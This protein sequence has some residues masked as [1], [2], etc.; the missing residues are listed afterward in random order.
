MDNI[1]GR[2]GEKRLL[3]E[4]MDSHEP[5]FLAIYG[6]RRVGK[7]FLIRQFFRNAN[8]CFEITG[9]QSGSL[10]NQLA[11]FKDVFSKQFPKRKKD[12]PPENWN[13]ALRRLIA[14]VDKK[15]INGKTVFFFDELPWLAHRKSNF[16]QALDSFWNSWAS[17]K[18]NVIVIVCGS[19]ASWMLNNI[20]HNKGGLHNR[21][22]RRIRLLPF[23]LKETQ[24]YLNSRGIHLDQKQ[25]L[26][27]YLAM[28]GVPHYLK[29]IMRGQ[30]ST[31]NIN[32]IC[33]TKEGLLTDEFGKLYQSLFENSDIY[34]QVVRALSKKRM[35]LA[36]EDLLKIIK[37]K[38]GGGI[39]KVLNALEESGFIARAIPF[40]QKAKNASYR[41][42]DEYSI[43]YLT[44]I[45]HAPK[46][47]L[48]K[49][50]HDY[51]LQ[52]RSTP[53]WRSWSG[54]AFESVC[55]K[56]TDQIKAGLGIG[57]MSTMESSWHYR[58]RS[59]KETGAQI[60]L[61]IDR[62]D[63]CITICEMKFSDLEFVID[64][65]YHKELRCKIDCF[66]NATRSKKTLFLA[67]LTT[68]GVKKNQYSEEIVSEDLKMNVLFQ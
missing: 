59:Q 58:P 25:I 15:N 38:T 12:L 39:T 18:K 26:E 28:G 68:Y 10:K 36:R 13:E 30:S 23:T 67:L 55:Q 40:G 33:F 17:R 57:G 1:I 16:L 51:W 45:E 22:T 6:R 34:M 62:S 8:F 44:W 48:N 14:E 52:K 29:Q 49:A 46:T 24:E 56:H 21:I 61:L 27:I 5:E 47:V 9:L 53:S 60:D 4:V 41:L 54:F 11:N 19:A 7:T 37:M 35:G 50:S 65:K 3:N 32:R 31:Q 63:N 66:K 43:F 20:V 2:E 64:K 42:I